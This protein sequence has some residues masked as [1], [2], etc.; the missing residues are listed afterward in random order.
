MRYKRST[1]WS[2]RVQSSRKPNLLTP[3]LR[4]AVEE[5]SRILA[6]AVA[7]EILA[8]LATQSAPTPPATSPS[9]AIANEPQIRTVLPET[10]FLRIRDL[11]ADPKRGTS[12]IIPVSRALWYSWI[13]SG[14]APKPVKFGQ[15]SVW[16]AEDIRA[17]IQRCST[18]IPSEQSGRQHFSSGTRRAFLQTDASHDIKSVR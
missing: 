17:F 11:V 1:S 5:F 10:G 9:L 8:E 7:D 6:R 13:A 3:Q 4:H 16:R 12:G 18:G 14:H 2:R 15:A